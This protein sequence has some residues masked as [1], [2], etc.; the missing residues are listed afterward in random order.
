MFLRSWNTCWHTRVAS[1]L[2]VCF[3]LPFHL[4][5]SV[6][7][8]LGGTAWPPEQ[9]H[10]HTQTES[11]PLIPSPPSDTAASLPSCR[12]LLLFPITNNSIEFPLLLSW[13]IFITAQ[14]PCPEGLPALNC[15]TAVVW[16][17]SSKT[18]PL[19]ANSGRGLCVN[20][21]SSRDRAPLA[22]GPP[23]GPLAWGERGL[24]VDAHLSLE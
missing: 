20:L 8:M 19:F 15:S 4:S 21:H 14:S 6:S 3:S 22:C 13:G 2:T 17:L 10:T 24:M 11:S 1:P 18:G 9:R 16:T 23:Q 5:F 7:F 12:C